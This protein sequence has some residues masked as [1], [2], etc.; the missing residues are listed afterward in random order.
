MID[1][2]HRAYQTVINLISNFFILWLV[3]NHFN[4]EALSDFSKSFLLFQYI[5]IINEWGFNLYSLEK[6]NNESYQTQNLIIKKI[7][8]GKFSLGIFT[9]LITTILFFLDIIKFHDQNILLSLL[10]LIFSSSVNPIWFFQ[11]INK[12]SELTKI[13]FL[14][15]FLQILFL[16]IM[17]AEIGINTIILS[18]ASIFTIQF[19]LFYL[20]VSKNINLRLNF[21][22]KLILKSIYELKKMFLYFLSNLYN[23]LNLTLWGIALIYFNLNSQLIIFNLIESIHR[24]VNYFL[25]AITEPIFK[26]INI[27]KSHFFRLF[28]LLFFI[29]ISYNL[30]K[31]ITIFVF[32][33]QALVLIKAF[34]LLFFLLI[35]LALSKYLSY[36]LI[37]KKIGINTLNLFNLIF[38]LLEVILF[39]L[40]ILFMSKDIETIILILIFA[41]IAKFIFMLFYFVFFIIKKKNGIL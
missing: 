37:A 29:I 35:L 5:F 16:I 15:R 23:H 26:F 40:W 22:F 32:P 34:Q 27:K 41:N 36:F 18:Q 20:F 6:I 7:F 9:C 12:S 21:N 25:Q 33:N 13:L 30:I 10:I 19:I 4:F 17:V 2:S 14:S 1:N 11:S 31:P 8:Y 24:G 38:L 3:Y 28:C 39:I